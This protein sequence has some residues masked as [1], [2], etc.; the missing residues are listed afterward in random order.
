MF[1]SSE[2]HGFPTS[3]SVLRSESFCSKNAVLLA[4]CRA[5]ILMALSV[6]TQ[7]SFVYLTE[8]IELLSYSRNSMAG[9]SA[10]RKEVRYASWD[11]TYL[12]N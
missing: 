12:S 6:L 5:D 11:R 3:K 9:K 1:A 10:D 4:T 8:L 2:L 7:Q